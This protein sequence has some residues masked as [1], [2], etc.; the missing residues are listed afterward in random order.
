[1]HACL[2][3][4]PVFLMRVRQPEKQGTA[5]YLSVKKDVVRSVREFHM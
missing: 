5:H 4:V 1:M 2:Y 3:R